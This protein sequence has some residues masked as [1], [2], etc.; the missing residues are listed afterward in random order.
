MD[1]L[2]QIEKLR[3]RANVSYDDAKA[4]YEAANGDL[5]DALIYLEKQG[6]VNPPSGDGYYSNQRENDEK[7][8]GSTND[9]HTKINGDGF[10]ETLEKIGKFCVRV[11]NK[12]N[13]TTFEILQNDESKA[14]FPLTVLVLLLLFVPWLTIPLLVAGL[15][16][17]FR[18]RLEGFNTDQF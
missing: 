11:I 10:L 5:L 8:P 12:G 17:N 2:A 1:R 16:F 6:K 4:A 3:E 15:F 14:R 7:D 9:R 13:S 18:Y